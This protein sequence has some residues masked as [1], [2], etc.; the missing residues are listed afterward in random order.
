M[1]IYLKHPLIVWCILAPIALAFIVGTL[2]FLVVS[3]LPS[4]MVQDLVA[5]YTRRGRA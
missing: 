4:P 2:I 5:R 1:E 3:F